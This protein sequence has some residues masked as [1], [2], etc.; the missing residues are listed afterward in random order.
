MCACP[1]AEITC[2]TASAGLASTSA[3]AARASA[4]V[5]GMSLQVEGVEGV[6]ER[7]QDPHPARPG[8]QLGLQLEQHLDVEREVV[9]LALEDREVHP[10]GRVQRAR[11]RGGEVA[12]RVGW[13]GW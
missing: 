4:A 13:K 11:G 3:S 2:A 1:T 9:D 10:P 12:L 6:V 8:R 5:P 7:L